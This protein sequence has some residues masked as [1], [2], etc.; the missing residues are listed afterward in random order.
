[1]EVLIKTIFLVAFLTG[2]AF[3]ITGILAAF[4]PSHHFAS[5]SEPKWWL[6]TI[7]ADESNNLARVGKYC[8][9]ETGNLVYL[10]GDPRG[11]IAVVP[12]GCK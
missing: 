7:H 12:G 6:Q 2:V 10:Y 3:L 9:T 8:D 5:A 11:G 1:M 4:L